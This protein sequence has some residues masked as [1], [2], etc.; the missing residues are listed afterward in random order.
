[1]NLREYYLS[2]GENTLKPLWVLFTRQSHG[3]KALSLFSV[4]LTNKKFP[5]L[6]KSPIISMYS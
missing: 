5:I 3:I 6:D 4:S 1:M 2:L